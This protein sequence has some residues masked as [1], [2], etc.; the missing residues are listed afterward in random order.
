M[1][2]LIGIIAIVNGLILL[3]RPHLFYKKDLA[4]QQIKRKKCIVLYCGIS[5]IIIGL[6][7]VTMEIFGE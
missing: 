3:F 6:G 4:P 1:A 2:I 7:L 5:L